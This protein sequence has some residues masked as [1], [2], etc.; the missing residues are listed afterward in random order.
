ML[1]EPETTAEKG[2]YHR[3]ITVED[4]DSFSIEFFL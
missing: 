1:G 4:Y 3:R 2:S